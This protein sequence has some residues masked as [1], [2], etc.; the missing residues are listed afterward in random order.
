M[1]KLLRHGTVLL[2]GYGA[3]VVE[4]S[5]IPGSKLLVKITIERMAVMIV[6]R[7]GCTVA[8]IPRTAQ[9]IA[10]FRN[11]ER[12]VVRI[13]NFLRAAWPLPSVEVPLVRKLDLGIAA[14]TDE[15]SRKAFHG[16]G[17][18]FAGDAR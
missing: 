12:A 9:P 10:K 15:R 8:G 1:W 16:F 2:I 5:K 14:D 13:E 7:H 6:I 4:I 18:M 3:A 11:H 17:Q